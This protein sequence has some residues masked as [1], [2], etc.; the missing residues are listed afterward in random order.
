[1]NHSR[2]STAARSRVPGSS[3]RWVAPG[4]I[5]IRHVPGITACARRLRSRTVSSR[6]P[7]INSVGVRTSVRRSPARSARPPR[8]TIA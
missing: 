1:M 2:A 7:T 5:S 8:E 3:N 6:E 4:T